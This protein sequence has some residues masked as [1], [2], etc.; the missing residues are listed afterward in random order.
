[1]RSQR[2]GGACV[3]GASIIAPG[4]LSDPCLG[5]AKF[6]VATPAGTSL[7]L[8][9]ATS[10]GMEGARADGRRDLRTWRPS[11]ISGRM[12]SLTAIGELPSL[13]AAAYSRPQAEGNRRLG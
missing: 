6:R 12:G 13:S 5:L 3:L 4:C 11:R 8:A 7:K 10:D 9:P 1:M 2:R